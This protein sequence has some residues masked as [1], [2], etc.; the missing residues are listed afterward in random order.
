VKCISGRR[1]GVE[2]ADDAQVRLVGAGVDHRA[3]R[4][5]VPVELAGAEHR[6]LDGD[7]LEVR[8]RERGIRALGVLF[9]EFAG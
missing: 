9:C 2:L 6:A 5:V 7:E 8:H 1:F 3:G 4:P